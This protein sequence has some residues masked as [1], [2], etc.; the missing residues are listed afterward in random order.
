MIDRLVRSPQVNRLP[1]AGRSQSIN[2]C[3]ITGRRNR[4]EFPLY[5]PGAEHCPT[6][7]F[8]REDIAPLRL[9]VDPTYMEAGPA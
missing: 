8:V 5:R 7:V 1:R 2:R 9:F 3:E 4:L 6:S